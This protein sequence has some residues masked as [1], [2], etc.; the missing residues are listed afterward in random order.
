[1]ARRRHPHPPGLVLFASLLSLLVADCNP[2]LCNTESR[3][4][5][6]QAVLAEIPGDTTGPHGFFALTLAEWRGGTATNSVS[7]SFQTPRPPEDVAIV[8]IR[9][10]TARGGELIFRLPTWDDPPWTPSGLA[11]QSYSGPLA[12]ADFLEAVRAG[13]AH[14]EVTF[15]GD[16]VPALIGPLLE[17]SYRDWSGKDLYCS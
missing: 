1:M 7:Y 3:F 13:D 11:P 4:L 17:T 5:D 2:Y 16:S 15:H 14:V 6:A 12:F 9:R 8:E 10:G